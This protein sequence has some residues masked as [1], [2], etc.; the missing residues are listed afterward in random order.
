MYESP[1]SVFI[2]QVVKDTTEQ[3]DNQICEYITEKFNVDVNRDELIKA[4]KYDRDQYEKGYRDALDEYRPTGKWTADLEVE[5]KVDNRL[6]EPID[7]TDKNA[8]LHFG[9]DREA[10][11]HC[12]HCGCTISAFT[13][14]SHHYCYVCGGRFGERHLTY[15]E[16]NDDEE[17]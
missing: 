1:I 12:P 7:I 8:G 15:E 9:Y 14:M 16:D 17:V 13:V 5:N 4:L 2:E 10:L 3:R 6:A 11:V